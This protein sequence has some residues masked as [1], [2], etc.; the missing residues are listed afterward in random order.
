MKKC[1]KC[2]EEKELSEFYKKPLNKD[3]YTNSCKV[4]SIKLRIEHKRSI[5]GKLM[6]IFSMMKLSQKRRTKT[7][8][9]NSKIFWIQKI[10]VNWF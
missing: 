5:K 9:R 8:F 4:C 10:F 1:T 6:H 3:G 7:K 2:G